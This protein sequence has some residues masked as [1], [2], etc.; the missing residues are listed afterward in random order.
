[1]LDALQ[2]GLVQNDHDV[3]ALITAA[4][5][6]S[7]VVFGF[8]VAGL[9]A[10]FRRDDA[11][12]TGG[13]TATLVLLTVLVAFVTYVIGN[14]LARAFGLVGALSIVRFRTSVGD[15]RDTS[16]VIFA[17]AIGMA[18]GAGYLKGALVALPIVAVACGLLGIITVPRFGQLKLQ[19]A[20]MSDALAG[21]KQIDAM[22]I[23]TRLEQGSTGKKNGCVELSYRIRLAKDVKAAALVEALRAQ[24][25]I[26]KVAW[27]AR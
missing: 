9:H 25:G 6:G 22:V 17:V 16:F 12:R 3:S 1:M 26:S 2:E 23:A 18:V 7:A 4:R 8:A 27:T 10:L 11:K 5:L 15:T 20:S 14:N 24:P 21:M 19:A 13:L